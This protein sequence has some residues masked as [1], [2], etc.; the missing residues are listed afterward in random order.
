MTYT[1]YKESRMTSFAEH[2]INVPDG[3]KGE[4]RAHCPECGPE[5]SNNKETLSVNV[6]KGVWLCH[7]CEWSGSL[8]LEGVH[9]TDSPSTG[10]SGRVN[11][12]EDIEAS[13]EAIQ[14]VWGDSST[15]ISC[16]IYLEAKNVGAHGI[17]VTVQRH[18]VNRQIIP[19]GSLLIPL[20]DV[21]GVLHSIQF[22]GTDGLKR[23][24]KGGVKKGQFHILG[25]FEQSEH[26]Y[27]AEGYA[28]AA[29]I[30]EAT[31]EAVVAAID[32]GNLVPVAKIIRDR[33]PNANIVL[34]ADNDSN[35]PNNPGVSKAT[36]AAREIGAKLA[37]PSFPPWADE[38]TDFNDL[39]IE[40]GTDTVIQQLDD[41]GE[42]PAPCG[43]TQ[44]MIDELN[45]KHAMVRLQGRTLILN[46]EYRP[47][48]GLIE[49]TFSTVADF[50]NFYANLP[51]VRINGK[52]VSAT[53]AWLH[54]PNQRQ[55]TRVDM[56]PDG[57]EEG[58]YNLWR[59]FAVEPAPGDCGL[60][61]D[62]IREVIA[63]GDEEIYRYIIAWIADAIQNPS[64]RPGVAIVLRGKQGT[65][66]GVFAK[67]LM[68]LFGRQHS[69][70][71]SQKSHLTGKFNA[72]LKHTLLVFADEA[73][74]AGDRS[75]AGPLKALVTEDYHLIELKG[76][77][78]FQVRNYV[79]LIIASN[80]D[81][82]VPAGPEERRFFVVDVS[83][84]QIQENEYF[85]RIE[86]QMSHGGLEALLDYLQNYDLTR[87]ELR[88]FPQTP[89]LLDQKVRSLTAS[90]KYF[91]DCLIAGCIIGHSDT[92][93]A[94][95]NNT[96]EDGLWPERV[97][98]NWMYDSFLKDMGQRALRHPP[99]REE[100]GT[101]IK[102]ACQ[103]I[104]RVRR[105]QR[106]TRYYVYLL[107]SLEDARAQFE[108]YIGQ[109]YPWPDER[110][111]EEYSADIEEDGVDPDYLSDD[112]TDLWDD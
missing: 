1:I 83:D 110:D 33:F 89:A 63:S 41:A 45:M 27:I 93:T 18:E 60:Y 112:N 28:T 51:P 6:D 94:Y 85:A 69:M 54:S 66:K 57:D 65:G 102:K 76:K 80:E 103:G 75:Q 32:C 23:N 47:T 46:E 111:G 38:L 81:W 14:R 37:V 52:T 34:A 87:V 31:G 12:A 77:D 90:Q 26:I 88:Y 95:M 98:T 101:Q 104:Q 48:S 29:S 99:S 86:E 25:N 58:T 97:R 43:P 40:Y 92:C 91:L 59:G 61:L 49:V 8:R 82:I 70:H 5:H 20:R 13:Q 108:E 71:I 73:F 9:C 3:A 4:V 107:P 17:R 78:A 96:G 16:H 7:R 50:R 105:M 2:G 10:E 55:Y 35:T 62:H 22:I 56:I 68:R 84:H 19:S 44:R 24:I 21:D 15:E 30:H 11:V 72:H 36:E 42:P 109:Q 106:G 64:T 79:R 53:T 100:F 67:Q 74:F 39:A